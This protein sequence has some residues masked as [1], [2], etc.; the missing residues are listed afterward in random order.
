MRRTAPPIGP[1]PGRAGWR[2]TRSTASR[3]AA[4]RMSASAPS[5]IRDARGMIPR[6]GPIGCRVQVDEPHIILK[7]EISCRLRSARHGKTQIH[8]GTSR[9]PPHSS[10]RDLALGVARRVLSIP[11]M[12]R[13]ATLSDGAVAPRP[14]AVVN[15][16]SSDQAQAESA[17]WSVRVGWLIVASSA[18]RCLFA[19]ATKLT[20]TEA[21]YASW[22][23]FPSLSYYDHAPVVAWLI[24][25]VGWFS[26]APN[27]PRLV[28]IACGALSS[29]MIFKLGER[30]FSPRAGFLAA[31]VMVCCPA[32]LMVGVLVNPEGPLAPL[33]LGALYLLDSLRD[34]RE[35]WRPILLGATVGEAFLCKYTALLLVPVVIVY[36]LT[37][38]SA[39]V[40]LRRPSLYLG[41]V[42]ALVTSLPVVYWNAQRGW[43][44]LQLHLSERMPPAPPAELVRHALHF[45]GTQGVIFQ[46]LFLPALIAAFVWCTRQARHDDRFRLLALACAPV[47]ALLAA[48]MIR[49]RDAESHWTMVAY[50]P[51]LVAAGAWLDENLEGARAPLRLYLGACLA[52]SG[53]LAAVGLLCI[54]TPWLAA[55]LPGYDPKEDPLNEAEGWDVLRADLQE[56]TRALGASSRVVGSHNVLC[57]HLLVALKDSQ[58]V[59]CASPTRTEFDFVGRRNPPANAPLLYVDNRRYPLEPAALFPDR[60]CQDVDQVAVHRG[61]L[62]VESFRVAECSPRIPSWPRTRPSRRDG[63]PIGQADW[64]VDSMGVDSSPAR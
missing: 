39:R 38:P 11:D 52:T 7:A 12:Q 41:G 15:L 25:S 60:R 51:L 36:L 44:T 42:V 21:Y 58:P 55:S 45:L 59:F 35:A 17:Y 48:M 4:A 16:R 54:Q 23:Y 61:P 40:W 64:I 6:P 1:S 10:S 47:W 18:I 50:L 22:A 14:N 63:A 19:G 31:L 2:R 49:V 43:P 62:L 46:P 9:R 27:A 29:W 30:L 3:A 5:S 34:R 13:A 53:S 32:F 37:T 56:R 26:H 20:D 24:G 33:W 8:I 28:P 57:G